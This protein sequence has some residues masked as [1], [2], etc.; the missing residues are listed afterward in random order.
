[1]LTASGTVRRCIGLGV[2]FA[3]LASIQLAS[4]DAT[5][6]ASLAG[7][8]VTMDH[9]AQGLRRAEVTLT[10]LASSF[11]VTEVSDDQGRFAFTRLRP[12][13]YLVTVSKSAYLTATLGARRE[14]RPGT[15]LVLNA[16]QHVADIIIALQRGGVITGIVRDMSGAGI[17]NLPVTVSAVDRPQ[18]RTTIIVGQVSIPAL[19][20]GR[21]TAVTDDRGRYR[22]FGLDPGEYLV[23]AIPRGDAG[24]AGTGAKTT[25]DGTPAEARPAQYGYAPMFHPG[26]PLAEDAARVRVAAGEERDGIDVT[27]DLVRTV[28][29]DGTLFWPDGSPGEGL[30]VELNTIGQTLPGGLFSRNGPPAAPDGRFTIVN[31]RP[32]RYL[33]IARASKQREQEVWAW[34]EVLASGVDISGITLTLQPAMSLSG[35]VLFEGGSTARPPVPVLEPRRATEAADRT[36]GAY[37]VTGLASPRSAMSGP[38]GRFNIWGILPGRFTLTVPSTTSSGRTW[39]LKSAVA[40]GRDLLDAP[41]EFAPPLQDVHDAVLTL[42]DRRTEL[43]GR[44][45]TADGQPA[46]EYFVIVFSADRAHWFPGTRRTRA[47]RPESDGAFSVTEL[48][49]GAYLIAAVTDAA[50]DEWQRP[51]FLEQLA[52]L[53]LPVTVP[54]GGIVRQDLQIAR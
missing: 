17:A 20:R 41:L 38:D 37:L 42:T 28:S 7:M 15:P 27:F 12:G 53:A 21:L 18:S 34:T 11:R 3:C 2:A 35:R 30:T 49:A 26:T 29:I 51:A 9:P 32:G 50:T 14:G 24:T 54:D 47:M 31:V 19:E 6:T 22:I 16:G 10:D 39:W 43:T 25:I 13:R 4:Q 1:M 33:L 5:A 46:T 40:G 23:G 36:S 44:L 45:Q 52:P 48:P 8:V